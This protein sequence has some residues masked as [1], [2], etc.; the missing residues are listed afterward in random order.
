MGDYG[1]WGHGGFA[2]HAVDQEPLT[3]TADRVSICLHL[4]GTPI[5]SNT[6]AE[7][8]PWKT[9]V[10]Q[11]SILRG[12]RF[13]FDRHQGSV[14]CQI[15]QLAAIASPMWLPTPVAGNAPLPIAGWKVAYVYF[16]SSRFIGRVGDPTWALSGI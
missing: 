8:C 4:R 1:D 16:I 10:E 2:H 14:L 11:G 12:I 7:K 5:R 3:I 6:R 13:Q 15:K 9:K